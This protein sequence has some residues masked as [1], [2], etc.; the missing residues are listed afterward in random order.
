MAAYTLS[1]ASPYLLWTCLALAR[2]CARDKDTLVDRAALECTC[3]GIVSS[4]H[5]LVKSRI[6]DDFVKAPRITRSPHPVCVPSFPWLWNPVRGADEMETSKH[7][8]LLGWVQT[9]KRCGLTDTFAKT[10][11]HDSQICDELS[12]RGFIMCPR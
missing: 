2:V 3:A 4:L 12:C 9:R 7:R 6:L 10:D 8:T 5:D 1:K 11:L